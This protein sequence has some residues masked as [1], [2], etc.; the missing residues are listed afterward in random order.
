MMALNQRRRH[1]RPQQSALRRLRKLVCVAGHPRLSFWQQN[2][3]WMAGTSPA[4]T[5]DI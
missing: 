2:K 5:V 1:A 4:M 3:S